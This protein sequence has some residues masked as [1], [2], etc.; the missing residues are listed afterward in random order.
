MADPVFKSRGHLSESFIITIRHKDRVI[1]ETMPSPHLADDLSPN[2]ALKG[3]EPAVRM[4]QSNDADELRLT[5]RTSRPLPHDAQQFSAEVVRGGR[6]GKTRRPDPGLSLK[7][8]DH[9]S[10]VIGD[11]DLPSFELYGPRFLDRI[12]FECFSIFFDS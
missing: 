11:R 8:V 2:Y 12:L 7:A 4:C 10:R 9:Q 6:G 1:A 3:A 5:I